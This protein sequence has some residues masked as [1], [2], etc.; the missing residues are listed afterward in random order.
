VSTSHPA[1]KAGNGPARTRRRAHVLPVAVAVALAAGAVAGITVRLTTG[2]AAPSAGEHPLAG[3]PC[4][5]PLTASPSPAP[6]AIGRWPFHLLHAGV[7]STVTAGPR[8]SVLALE[9]CGAEEST[10]RVVEVSASGRLQG[11]SQRFPHLAPVA[12]SVAATPSA[13][14]LGGARLSL[15]GPASEAPYRLSLVELDPRTLTPERTLELGRGYGLDLVH[16]SRSTLLVS[17]GR[18]L[19][20]LDSSGRLSEL[21]AFPGL[22]VQHVA[23]LPGGRA[24]L[25]SLFTP[26]PTPPQP[27]TRLALVALPAGRLLSSLAVRGPAEVSS[28]VAGRTAALASVWSGGTTTVERFSLTP[29]LALD[30]PVSG[31]VPATLTALALAGAG[32]AGAPVLVFGPSTLACAAG[33]GRLLAST[34]PAG[35]AEDV[36]SIAPSLPGVAAVVP[37]GVGLVSLPRACIAGL[38]RW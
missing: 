17:T 24:A 29:R 9:A 4:P 22:V 31:T 34:T 5:R 1:P 26:A 2:G 21:A 7:F 14:W 18:Q 23:P 13:V 12:S 38:G 6:R 19:F 15:V 28:I 10:L 30:R 3:S 8:G 16:L 37:A 27:S 35:L 25:V 11:T 32:P 33:S 20:E 36:S